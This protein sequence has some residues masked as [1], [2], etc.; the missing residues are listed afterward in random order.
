M[1]ILLHKPESPLNLSFWG[2]EVSIQ[3]CFKWNLEQVQREYLYL[4]QQN[5]IEKAQEEISRGKNR[6][7]S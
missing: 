2:C 4:E 3:T 7:R 6:V 1:S 5:G